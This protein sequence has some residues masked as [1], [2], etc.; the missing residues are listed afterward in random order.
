MND[1]FYTMRLLPLLL[2][3]CNNCKYYIDAKNE[4]GKCSIFLKTGKNIY[5]NQ[6]E[7]DYYY[8][9]TARQYKNMCGENGKH[10]EKLNI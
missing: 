10:Y 2:I 7:I 1:L 4:V 8:S 9:S 6:I 3:N 5:P